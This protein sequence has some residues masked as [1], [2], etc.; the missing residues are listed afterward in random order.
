MVSGPKIPASFAGTWSGTAIQSALADAQL[1]QLPNSITL[2]LAAG[3]VTA[4]EENQSCVNTLILTKVT[5]TTLTFNEPGVPG[6]CVAGTVTLKRKGKAL[7]YRWTDGVEQ[8]AGKL[9]KG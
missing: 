7:A 2:T 1:V 3:G 6:T 9:S 8:N 4:H 5:A